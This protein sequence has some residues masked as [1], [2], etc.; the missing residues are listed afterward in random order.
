M[1]LLLNSLF[2]SFDQHA[3][4]YSKLLLI[5]IILRYVFLSLKT[6]GKFPFVTLHIETYLSILVHFLKNVDLF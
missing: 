6:K 4:S 1:E 2:C 5:I 3:H